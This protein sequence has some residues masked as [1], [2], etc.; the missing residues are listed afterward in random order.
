MNIRVLGLVVAAGLASPLA[1][2][3]QMLQ[4]GLWELSSSSIQ[5]E[6]QQLPDLQLMLGQLQQSLSPE[7]RK[8]LEQQG[9][10]LGG[11]GARVC[12]TQAQVQNDTIPLMDPQSG[13]KQQITERSAQQWRFSFSCPQAQGSGV[14]QF[15][16]DREFT[17]KVSGTFNVTGLQQRGSMESKATWLG[18]DCGTVKPR[19]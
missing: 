6:G 16:S 14:A 18:Q 3:A 15:A 8:Q 5:V 4:P 13:C 7:Q 19:A 2:Q 10:T 12:L 1:A 11:K 17:T 9:L